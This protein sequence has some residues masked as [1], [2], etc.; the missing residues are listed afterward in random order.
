MKSSTAE[1]A[2]RLRGDQPVWER[3]FT[4]APLVLVGTL[5]AEDGEHD[6]A[7][8]HMTMPLGW[9]GEHFCFSCSPRHTTH[10]NALDTGAFTV[11]FMRPEAIIETSMAAAPRGP[12]AAKPSLTAV[13]TFPAESVDGVLAEGAY[14]WLECSLD[15]IIDGFGANSLIIGR[16][17]SAAVAPDCLRDPEHDDADLLRSRPLLA[18]VSPG[19]FAAV[20]E[21]HSFPYPAGFSP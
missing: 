10:R 3:V 16:I 17:E 21:T 9:D 5:A 18:Y 12:D 11:S 1:D 15:R 19:R 14:L 13:R 2:I 7:P 20:G 6:L 8:K 4:V